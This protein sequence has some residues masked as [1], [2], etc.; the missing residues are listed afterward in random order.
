MK[1]WLIS[2]AATALLTVLLELLLSEGSTKKYIQGIVRVGLVLVM[3]TPV[4]KLLSGG[5]NLESMFEVSAPAGEERS[6]GFN[7]YVSSARYREAEGT[8]Q[9]KIT[10]AGIY[11]STVSINIYYQQGSTGINFVTVDLNNAV[12]TRDGLN[13][14][15]NV[16]RQTVKSVLEI[17]EEKI[18]IYGKAQEQAN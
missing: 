17:E 5:V 9:K 12:I 11:G 14:I 6:V 15:D 1:A 18:L 16:V 13:N 4:F 2:V 8:I 10:Q 7:E 3:I